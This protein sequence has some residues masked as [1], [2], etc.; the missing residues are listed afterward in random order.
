MILL[1]NHQQQS[2][3]SDGYSFNISPLVCGFDVNMCVII[4]Q[5]AL[6]VFWS[7]LVISISS[8]FFFIM[9]IVSSNVDS[10]IVLSFSNAYRR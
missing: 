7:V 5:N 6:H 4:L 10:L 2:S 8:I 3:G 1:Q 9:T